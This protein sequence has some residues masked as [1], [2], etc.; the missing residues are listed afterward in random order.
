[1]HSI[2]TALETVKQHHAT[3]VEQARSGAR[4]E[5]AAQLNQFLRRL[6]QYSAED[7]FTRS[8]VDG[9]LLFAPAAAFFSIDGESLS[10]RAEKGL[11]LAAGLRFPVNLGR[12]FSHAIGAKE[13]VVALRTAAEVGSELAANDRSERAI[14]VPIQN[15]DRVPAVLFAAGS[16]DT[17]GVDLIAGIASGILRMR[18]KQTGLAELQ[19]IPSRSKAKFPPWTALKEEQQNLHRRAQRF[20]RV[21][22]SEWLLTKPEAGRAGLEQN[23][24]YLFLKKEIDTARESFR[25][26]FTADKS[27]VDYLHLELVSVAAEGDES[28]LG[29]D[30]PGPLL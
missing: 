25:N 2:D 26:Q 18:Q 19:P 17:E 28:K 7:E 23:D 5:L 16:V 11:N 14:I 21:K 24:I 30:Y 15:S 12:A 20:A 22:V 8:V 27:M 29:T 4:A 1:M 9:A 10:L 13:L 3:A 6:H